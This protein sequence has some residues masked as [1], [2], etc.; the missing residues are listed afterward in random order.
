MRTDAY[1][2]HT[3]VGRGRVTQGRGEGSRPHA[4]ERV[5]RS[6]W[7]SRSPSG[8]WRLHPSNAPGRVS[9]AA[10]RPPSG[11]RPCGDDERR[12]SPCVTMGRAKC[13]RPGRRTGD[14]VSH[15]NHYSRAR[16]GRGADMGRSPD[17]P[18]PRPRVRPWTVGRWEMW[19]LRGPVVAVVL[20]VCGTAALLVGLEIGSLRPTAREILMTGALVVLG[21]VHTEIA[22][23]V[24]RMRRR[25]SDTSY[26]DLSSVW[27][28]AAARC[29]PHRSPR[30]SSSRCTCTCG[31]GCGGPRRASSTAT[32]TPPPRSSWRPR[33]RTPSSAP[34]VGSRAGAPERSGWPCS[35]WPSWPTPWSTTFS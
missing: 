25:V 10:G 16:S 30:P 7:T 11:R 28:F 21:L 12:L 26:Y 18:Y 17:R 15:W 4:T 19:Q 22:S 27:T 35:P 5:T 23:K 3:S 1:G 29:S 8:R 24:E 2:G 13:T 33:P 31:C 20:L 14:H 32:S 6:G 34:R 9:G